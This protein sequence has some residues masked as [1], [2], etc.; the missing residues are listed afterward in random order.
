MSS[1]LIC[2]N[3]CLFLWTVPINL[4]VHE[5]LLFLF[6]SPAFL[7]KSPI[8]P[9]PCRGFICVL[10]YVCLYTANCMKL[11]SNPPSVRV[12]SAQDPG[13]QSCPW[14]ED[15]GYIICEPCVA[16]IKSVIKRTQEK[17]ERDR[18]TRFN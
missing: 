14:I 18:A 1:H 4:G 11:I 3:V 8:T 5:A 9:D 15:N 7:I 10:E 17:T 16:V 12:L 13:S 6:L 2:T